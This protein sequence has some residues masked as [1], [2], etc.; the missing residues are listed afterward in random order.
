MGVE[1][2]R[3]SGE[4]RA[5]CPD[6]FTGCTA[7]KLPVGA[8]SRRFASRRFVAGAFRLIHGIEDD[9]V[10]VSISADYHA[11]AAAL[12]KWWKTSPR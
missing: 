6:S 5:S 2:A 1:N 10:P 9:T 8:G 4:E 11:R 7:E 12:G 3:G